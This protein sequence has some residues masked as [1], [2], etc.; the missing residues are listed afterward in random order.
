MATE[1]KP[2]LVNMSNLVE[3]MEGNNLKDYLAEIVYN[4]MH[5]KGSL[6]NPKKNKKNK[7]EDTIYEILDSSGSISEERIK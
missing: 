1:A 3:S 2:D 4:S 7:K 5:S 6:S